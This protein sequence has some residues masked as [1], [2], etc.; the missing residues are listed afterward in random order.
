MLH[1]SYLVLGA[2]HLCLS[3]RVLINSNDF[4][5]QFLLCFKTA[6]NMNTP[7]T[8]VVKACS[9]LILSMPFVVRF[10]FIPPSSIVPSYLLH[11]FCAT[12]LLI[13]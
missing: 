13:D 12:H 1:S 10:M 8:I 7:V 11:P 6:L 4:F 9:N 3:L 5:P 2:K